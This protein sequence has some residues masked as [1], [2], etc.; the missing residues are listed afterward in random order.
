MEITVPKTRSVISCFRMAVAAC[1]IVIAGCNCG[2]SRTVP[3]WT[4]YQVR[5]PYEGEKPDPYQQLVV[6]LK[7]GT[8][9]QDFN[10]WLQDSIVKKEKNELKIRF[11]CGSCDSSLFLLEGRGVEVYMQGEVAQGGSGSR[12]KPK[13]TGESGPL[14]FSTN[15]PVQFPDDTNE[16]KETRLPAPPSFSD[17]VV[18]V[19]VFDTGLDTAL[20]SAAFLYKTAD[21]ACIPGGSSG[22][23][24]TAGNNNWLD[25]NPGR[26]GSTVTKFIIDESERYKKNSIA[27]LPVKIFDADGTSDLYSILCGFAYAKNRKVSIINASFGYYESRNKYDSSG[28]ALSELTAPVLLKAFIEEHLTKNN[29]LLI[30][31]AGNKDDAIEDPE[32]DPADTL[33][34]R[35]LDSVHFYPASLSPLLPNV[36]AITTVYKNQVS[37]TQNFSNKVV[38]AGVHADGIDNARQFFFTNPVNTGLSPVAGSSFAAPVATGKFAAWYYT[39]KNMLSAPLTMAKKDSIFAMLKTLPDPVFLYN[40]AGLANKTKEGKVIRK[41]DI[42]EQGTTVS[43]R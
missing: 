6:W 22:W 24:F 30:A 7:P 33:Q 12:S 28:N 39:Y 29:I 17:P 4:T 37:P 31:A 2:G 3:D 41:A 20:I 26:H 9:R 15:I 18:N 42:T 8:S 16:P 13:V 1:I 35:N 36:I 38:D 25:D 19:A 10:K 40:E 27:V 14:Y 5:S 34:K 32:Y 11:V 23:N 43:L 21:S